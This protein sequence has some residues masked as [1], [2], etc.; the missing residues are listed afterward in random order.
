VG[1]TGAT[2]HPKSSAT[3][4]G[5]SPEAIDEGDESNGIGQGAEPT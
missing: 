5:S 1:E 2:H 3:T 4:T